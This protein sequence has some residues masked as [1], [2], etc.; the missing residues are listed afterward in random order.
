[1]ARSQSQHRGYTKEETEAK[2][3]G[4]G[5]PVARWQLT[6]GLLTTQF[7]WSYGQFCSGGTRVGA[8]NTRPAFWLSGL[9]PRLLCVCE[10]TWEIEKTVGPPSL[11]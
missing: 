9:G 3:W 10:S 7:E 6:P 1:M 8:H 2:K 11:G 5:Y 4:Y